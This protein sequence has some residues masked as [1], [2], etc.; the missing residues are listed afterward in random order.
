VYNLA[1]GIAAWQGLTAAGSEELGMLLLQGNETPQEIIAL[2]YGLE[3]GL[4]KFYAA[5]A[6]LSIK[7]EVIEVL[8][9][10]ADIEVIHK[11]RLFELYLSVESNPLEKD[12]F[13]ADIS[14]EMTEGGFNP[15]KLIERNLPTFQSAGDVLQFAMMLE[16]QAMDLYMR[17]A[18]KCEVRK[19][20]D[21]LHK[22]ADEE[23]AHLRSL[24]ELLEK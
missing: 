23:K 5:A 14:S 15:D 7:Q 1:G 3:S 21:I 2:S 8:A 17:Y 20:K 16:A 13:E 24:A 6:S 10:L 22:M 12:A 11:E 4:H 18:D 19:V 9:K